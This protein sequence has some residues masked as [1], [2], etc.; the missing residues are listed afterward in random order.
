MGARLTTWVLLTLCLLGLSRVTCGQIAVLPDSLVIA[1]ELQVEG[2]QQFSVDVLRQVLGAGQTVS[3]R[4]W[5][6]SL[7]SLARLYAD[8]GFPQLSLR[9]P[10]AL[11]GTVERV[12]LEEGPVLVL[13]RVTLSPDSLPD[14]AGLRLLQPGRPL[15]AGV[16]DDAFLTILEELESDG[17]ALATLEIRQAAFFPRDDRL[18]LDLDLVLG[19]LE[20]IRPRAVRFVGLSNSLPLT[21]ERLGRL[22]S[23]EVWSPKRNRQ[24]RLRLQRSGWFSSVTGPRL[25]RGPEGHLLLVEVEE[26]PSYHFEGLVGLL[27]GREN[28]SSRV[29]FLLALDLENLLGTGRR[30]N[31]KAARPDGVSQELLFRYREPFVFG[32]P[33]GLGGQVIQQIQDSTWLSRSGSLEADWELVPGLEGGASL[34][35]REIL[36]DSLNGWVTLGMDHS[37]A[38]VAG[39]W[40]EADFRD[41]ALNPTRG[42]RA[43]LRT[44]SVSRKALT[45]R[46]LAARGEDEVFW[47]QQSDFQFYLRPPGGSSGLGRLV[48]SLRL[49]AGRLSRADLQLEERFALGGAA[50]P[51]G[52]RENQFRASTWGLGQGELRWRLGRASRTYLFWDWARMEAGTDPAF[53]RQGKGAGIRLPIPQGVLAVEYAL[54]E[55]LGL[56]EGLIHVKLSS[57]F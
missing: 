56:R 18:E 8:A 22:R 29:S 39:G 38:V 37:S 9:A 55:G 19:R 44:E 4:H 12:R 32:L 40:L 54:G 7:D 35:L 25:A 27:P 48:F 33:L 41:D 28:E 14:L 15:R 16:L 53:T 26:L 42:W 6:A 10:G 2:N 36:P 24:A 11:G 17:R 20:T 30:L 23:G 21:L 51:R 1:R 49:A 50:G 57:R 47:R 43:G 45:F 52:Y 5:Q 31:L 46:G 13:G 3:Q 34:A